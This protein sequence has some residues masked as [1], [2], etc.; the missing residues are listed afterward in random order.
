MKIQV[1]STQPNSSMYRGN[2]RKSMINR[3]KYPYINHFITFPSLILEFTFSE[4]IL[5]PSCKTQSD[6][7]LDL[8]S[9]IIH[10]IVKNNE[11]TA[12][13]HNIRFKKF[14][15]V[16]V[17]SDHQPLALINRKIMDKINQIVQTIGIDN[18]NIRH[19][20]LLVLLLPCCISTFSLLNSFFLTKLSLQDLHFLSHVFISFAQ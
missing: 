13:I 1:V 11:N 8:Q 10:R 15:I 20:I 9:I 2:D 4:S 12:R 19:Q 14:F 3:I 17:I 16:T 6:F 5:S 7:L 18:A